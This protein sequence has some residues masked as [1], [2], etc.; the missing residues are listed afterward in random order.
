MVSSLDKTHLRPLQKES[1]LAIAKCCDVAP[2]LP[3]LQ[4]W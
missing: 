3:E 2:G 1:Y 4:Q